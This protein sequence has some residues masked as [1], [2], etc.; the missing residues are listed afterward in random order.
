MF[1]LFAV[2]LDMFKVELAK[3][4]ADADGVGAEYG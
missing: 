3:G 2:E 4:A 1:D